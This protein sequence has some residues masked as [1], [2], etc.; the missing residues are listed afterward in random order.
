MQTEKTKVEAFGATDVWNHLKTS[1]TNLVNSASRFV[2][3]PLTR[4]S[5]PWVNSKVALFVG[6]VFVYLK[7]RDKPG[8]G[9]IVAEVQGALERANKARK[10]G[11]DQLIVVA[12]SMG[13]NIMYD[14]LTSS[15]QGITVDLFLTV[16]SQVGLFEELKLFRISN[17]SVTAPATVPKPANVARWINVM[18]P[19]DIL[20]YA[21]SRIF[22]GS[23]D[24]KIDNK[25]P[26]WSAHSAYFYRPTFHQRLRA[27]ILEG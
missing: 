13:G 8:G 15:A 7:S 9:E 6:D 21:T 3:N 5:R 12:H 4:A 19:N 11:D 20:A 22:A 10:S 27:R 23:M 24:T 16:G 17:P 26:V 2:V 25:A 14:I 18:D 1:A